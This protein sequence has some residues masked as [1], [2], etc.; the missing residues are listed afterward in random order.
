EPHHIGSAADRE[1][2]LVGGDLCLVGEMGDEFVALLIDRGHGMTAGDGD[3]ARAHLIAQ[4]L[5]Y[6]VIKAAQDVLAA[7]DERHLAAEA[8]EDA[9]ELDSDVATALDD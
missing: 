4:V 2:H 5:A 1:H 6:V 7:I 3:A 9:G 8:G